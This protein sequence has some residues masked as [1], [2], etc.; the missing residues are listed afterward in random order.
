MTSTFDRGRELTLLE[1]RKSGD[2]AWKDLAALRQETA[3]AVGV[4]V[5]HRGFVSRAGTLCMARHLNALL[6]AA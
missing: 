3:E 2:S 5:V 1:R 6:K 4:L